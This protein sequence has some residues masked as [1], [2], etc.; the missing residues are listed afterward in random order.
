MNHCPYWKM[1]VGTCKNCTIEESYEGCAIYRYAG[2]TGI[3]NVPD[4]VGVLDHGRVDEVIEN[5]INLCQK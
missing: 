5:K 4:Y 1:A 2:V 3:F